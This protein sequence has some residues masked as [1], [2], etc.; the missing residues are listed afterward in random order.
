[1]DEIFSKQS[2]VVIDLINR[3]AEVRQVD[4]AK[5][6]D[7]A[8]DLFDLAH[9]NG[10]QDLKDYASC[11]LGDACCL[12]NDFS[13][14]FYYLSSGIQG[15]A[16]TDEYMLICQCYNEL[17]VI[18][19][20]QGHFIP[21]EENFLNSIDIA[22]ANRLAIQEA[23]ACSN[24]AT[25]CEGMDAYQDSIEYHYRSIEC[26]GFIEVPHIKR[27]LLIGEYALI[28]KLYVRMKKLEEAKYTIEE[29][30]RLIGDDVSYE[31]YFDV[32]V[33][34]LYYNAACD[35]TELADKYKKKSICAIYKCEDFVTYFD[36]I[37]A[38]AA[39][40]LEDGD[41]Q[42]LE[43]IFEYIDSKEVDEELLNLRLHLERFKLAMYEKRGDK[44]HMME[45]AYHYFQLHS[46]QSE[47]S[48]K[49]FTTTLRLRSELAQQKTRNMFLSAAAETDPLTGIANRFKLNTVID[50]LFTWANVEAKSLG[51]EM[52][53]IDCFK[54]VNDTYGHTSGDELLRKTGR[55]LHALEDEKIFVAR[56]GGDEFIV[57]YYDMTDEEIIEK[58]RY[59]KDAME[60]V[61]KELDMG[62]IT[63]S[64]GIVN[65]V[66][67]HMNRTWDYLN[68]ADLALY[69]VKN[70]GKA[71]ARL[72][73][74]ATDL[75]TEEWK[76]VF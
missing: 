22:R 18:Y 1:M 3:I 34:R 2:P 49:S 62:E 60:A 32:N 29:M 10:N 38:L 5:H 58:A 30:D 28:T 40:L 45:S 25:L 17:G 44:E 57:Y 21:S 23:V 51:V 52:L 69:F 26:C 15:V 54:Q 6:L 9:E 37:Q 53:D 66:P 14:A 67:R 35:N 56:Y 75:Q 33:T 41:Y 24:F 19:R 72:I 42:E 8:C 70:H 63:V 16:S 7:L 65:H 27:E 43:K 68:A 71:N 4:N 36:E 13:Q 74:R 12:N 73:H 61:G 39:K 47:D 59:I 50:E 11:V 55:I 31:D 48:K 64:Q 46:R 20:S 76:K